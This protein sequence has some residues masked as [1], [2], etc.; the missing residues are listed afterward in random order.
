MPVL[1][2][3][4]DDRTYAVLQ[5]VACNTG[6]TVEQLAEAAI[7]NEAVKCLPV[8]RSPVIHPLDLG[9]VVIGMVEQPDGSIRIVP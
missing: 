1:S 9:S 2:C 6:R 3:Y 7:E 5:N 4:V 8:P